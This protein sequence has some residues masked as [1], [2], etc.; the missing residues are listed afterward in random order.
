M[1]ENQELLKELHKKRFV[2]RKLEINNNLNNDIEENVLIRHHTIP[3][4]KEIC[5]IPND[6]LNDSIINNAISLLPSNYNFEIHKTIWHIRKNNIKKVGL[7]MPEGLLI[8]ACT[9]SDI[10]ESICSV[11]VFIMGDVTY[12]ACC[13]DDFTAKALDCDL[14]IHYGHS[15]LVPIDS[16]LVKTLYIFV[17]IEINK[18]H[19]IETIKANIPNN[20]HIALV[21]TIQFVP[22]IHSIRPCLENNMDNNSSYKITVPQSKPLSPGE[23]L[24]CTAPTLNA[25]V[26][27]IIYIGDGRFHLES[28]MIA[29]PSLPA[30]KYDPYSGKFTREY[31]E[32]KNMKDMRKNAIKKASKAKKWGLII[33]TLGRQGSLKVMQNLEVQ[34]KKK[35]I[36]YVKILISEIFP[37]KLSQ[38]HDINA[39]VQIACPRLSI[40]WGY[41]FSAPLLSPYEAFVALD[42]IEWKDVYPMDFYANHSLG[43]W[44]PNHC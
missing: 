29:N 9:I 38:F 20:T 1:S 26:D 24:G 41:A 33:G 12:G 11:D 3:K 42:G 28:I 2:A 43:P 4:G 14:L 5:K 13:I 19:V 21:G 30:Y 34:L 6:I 44:T 31:Y 8:F 7:Q 22:T 32:H 37:L 16:V 15:C 10:L 18:D 35:K 40:D 27:A 25:D 17:N 39:W 23:I 36:E